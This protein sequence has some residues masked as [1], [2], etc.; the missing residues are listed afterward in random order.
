[1]CIRDRSSC[2]VDAVNALA[3]LRQ[4]GI[5]I[6]APERETIEAVNRADDWERALLHYFNGQLETH[7]LKLL[8]IGTHFDEYQ[9][10]ACLPM[11]GLG[12]VTALEIMGRLGIVY[13][14]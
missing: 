12:L 7:D 11:N 9:A 13:K 6:I 10:F 3:P 14:Y 1:M 2:G 8:A 5:E 4:L